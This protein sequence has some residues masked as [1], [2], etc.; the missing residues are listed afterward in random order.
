M[1]ERR[2]I[3]GRMVKN[4]LKKNVSSLQPCAKG[5]GAIPPSPGEEKQ[6]RT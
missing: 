3:A 1:P 2:S 5:K 4:L 6:E